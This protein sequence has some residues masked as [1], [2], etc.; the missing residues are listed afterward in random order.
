MD[1]GVLDQPVLPSLP[2]NPWPATKI[3]GPFAWLS[4][5]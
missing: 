5:P 3:T 4:R 2:A 1:T